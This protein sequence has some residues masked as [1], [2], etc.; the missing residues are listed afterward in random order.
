MWSVVYAYHVFLY[1]IIA[2]FKQRMMIIVTVRVFLS[3]YNQNIQSWSG[4]D[5]VSDTVSTPA[6]CPPVGQGFNQSWMETELFF[7]VVDTYKHSELFLSIHNWWCEVF[8]VFLLKNYYSKRQRE[9]ITL[10]NYV[11]EYFFILF[12]F[13]F[14]F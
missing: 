1:H 10:F 12:F 6:H 4:R 14:S 13:V 8:K 9:R 5:G 7:Y 11:Q 3:W 2:N